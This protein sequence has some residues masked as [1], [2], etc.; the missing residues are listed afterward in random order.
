VKDV[1]NPALPV[2]VS[3]YHTPDTSTYKVAVQGE[4]VY[5]TG[6]ALNDNDREVLLTVDVAEKDQPRQAGLRD[7]AHSR[8]Q[9]GGI[10]A[11]GECLYIP[12][13]EAGLE[14]LCESHATPTP[15]KLS[16]LPL[17]SLFG[18]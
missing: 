14:I 8:A 3:H 18:G 10:V 11:A 15:P 17:Y 2:L 4:Q 16:F 6:V 1:S 13:G 12:Q 9:S 5:A 7:M